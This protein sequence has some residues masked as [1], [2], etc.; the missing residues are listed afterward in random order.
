MQFTRLGHSGLTVSRFALGCMS[1]GDPGWRP[2]VMDEAAARPFFQRAV[3][4]GINFFDTADMYSLGVSEQVTGRLIRELAVRDETVIA[5]K[6]NFPMSQGPNMGG[7][8]RKHVLQACDA[9]G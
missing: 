1:Y 9:S 5:T 2:W 6:V 8:S 7:L 3:E 4:A